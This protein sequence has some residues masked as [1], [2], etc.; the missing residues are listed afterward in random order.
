MTAARQR[1]V[2]TGLGAV[3]AWGWSWRELWRGLNDASTRV[4]AFDRFDHQAQRTHVAGQVP[5]APASVRA[6]LPH[7]D[8]L[9]WADRFALAAAREAVAEAA[10]SD[11][12]RCGVFFASSTGGMLEGERYFATAAGYAPGRSSLRI[13]ESHE[14]NGPGDAVARFFAVGGPVETVST[15][16]ASGGL[17]LQSALDALRLGELELALCGGADELCRLTYSGFNSLRA[18]DARACQPFRDHRSGMSLGEGAAVLVLET[19]DAAR[20][21]GAPIVA[22]LLGAGAS[23]DAHHMTAPQAT[24]EGA[25]A[26]LGEAL[27][28]AGLE[29]DEVDFVNVHGT[30]T[31]QNDAA[32]WQA[33]RQVFGSRTGALPL[34]GVKGS[35][36]HLLG[37]AGSIEALVTALS[38]SRGQ[39]P[40]SAGEGEI[41]PE[42]DVSL[43]QEEAKH[44]EF[45]VGLSLSLAFGGANAA[46]V[47]RRAGV[48]PSR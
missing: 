38:L 45:D 46:V 16:C 39:V 44:G 15:A 7:W 3:S 5:P 29:P 42:L 24:G 13:L 34:T 48:D 22:E 19:L 10:L 40:P 33:L 28:D 8:G 31:R 25:A 6:S 37:S 11:L 17:A 43:V 9:S 18:V 21:R 32:E 35:I 26:A 4:Q 41:D 23:C 14:H 20:R 1:V 47:L 2:I 12:E 30:G 27:A 36:G